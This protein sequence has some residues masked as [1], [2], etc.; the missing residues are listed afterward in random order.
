V[1]LHDILDNV[2]YYMHTRKS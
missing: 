2:S 1:F